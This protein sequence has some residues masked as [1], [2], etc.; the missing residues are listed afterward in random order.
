MVR[1]TLAGPAERSWTGRGYLGKF[2]DEFGDL[3]VG[4]ER[5]GDTRGSHKRVKGPSGRSGTCRGTL[6]DF[7]D[8]SGD[9]R[10]ESETGPGNL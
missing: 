10:G 4:P 9:P 2:W 6:G 1:W 5:S 3:R 7:R 8:G